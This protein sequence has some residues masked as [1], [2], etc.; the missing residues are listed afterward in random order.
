MR[1]GISVLLKSERKISCRERGYLST[2]HAWKNFEATDQRWIIMKITACLGYVLFRLFVSTRL[3]SRHPHQTVGSKYRE[4]IED[5]IH[6]HEPNVA[7]NVSN[8][9]SAFEI[10]QY[11]Q[12]ALAYGLV[13][14]PPA[15]CRYGDK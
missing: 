3:S 10:G 13:T 5:Y 2:F 1:S 14:Y 7:P 11:W 8:T 6:S 4:N 12:S 15:T 9:T